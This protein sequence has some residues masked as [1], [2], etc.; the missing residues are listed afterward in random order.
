MAL[1]L[2]MLRTYVLFKTFDS[3]NT[4]IIY[5]ERG[6]KNCALEK[7]TPSKP[8]IM[9]LNERIS[10]LEDELQIVKETNSRQE[11]LGFEL[12]KNGSQ[13]P[14]MQIENLE[15][16][17]T[18]TF[19]KAKTMINESFQKLLE[20]EK[21]ST[22]ENKKILQETVDRSEMK[23]S[24][25]VKNL[26]ISV[27][28]LENEIKDQLKRTE[29]DVFSH[30]NDFD[31]KLENITTSIQTTN[32]RLQLYGV[33][34]NSTIFLLEQ[35]IKNLRMEQ[36][37]L[38]EDVASVNKKISMLKNNVSNNSAVLQHQ[39]S[40]LTSNMS[41]VTDE[42]KNNIS[43]TMEN[44]VSLIKVWLINATNDLNN[45]MQLELNKSE[46]N[47]DQTVQNISISMTTL[48]KEITGN[49]NN[50]R[51]DLFSYK[52]DLQGK[53]KN[54]T[55]SIHNTNL[56]LELGELNNN[57]TISLLE[58]NL[59]NLH[60][61]QLTLVDDVASANKE[62]SMLISNLTKTSN[63]LQHQFSDFTLKT[64]SLTEEIK[65]EQHDMF[66][67]VAN[68][69]SSTME[70][71]V[72]L[73]KASL[74]NATN[75]M[76]NLIQL[77]LN[78]S[79]SKIDLTVQN[80]SI[81]MT[82]LE[83]EITDKLNNVRQD[84]FSYKNDLQGKLKNITTSIHNTNV[85]LELGELNNNSTISLLEQNLQN[86]HKEQLTLV[87]DVASA[88]KE[89][90]MLISN[91][92]KTSNVLQHQFSDFTLKTSSLTEEI[93]K[94]QHD[95]FGFVAN[96]ISSTME[97]EVSL[98]KASLTNATNTMNN[99][100]QLE[101]NKS[102]SKKDQ[103]V[104]N[105]SISMT[106]LENEIT[107]MLN[108][109]RQ[110]LF[111][112][113]NDLQGKL[114]NITTSIH[115]TNVRL[116]LGE[117]NNNST[118][119][120][121][122]QNL[123]N[124][125]KEQLTL[126]DDVASANKEIS[127]L[128]SN[129]T[130]TSNVLQNQFSEFTS[131]MSSLKEEIKKEQHDTFGFVANNISSAVENEVSL[132]KAS[133]TNATN[134]VNN[135]IQLE[136][137]KSDSKI[138]L[139][140]QNISISLTMLENGITGKLKNIRQDVS[141]YKNDLQGTLENITTSIQTTIERLELDVV[142][143]NFTIS[144][145][146]HN[147]QNLLKEQLTLVDDVG[148]ANKE[149]NML[150]TNL[151]KTLN[152]L[153]QQSSELTS[154]MSSWTK[155]IKKEQHDMFGFVTNNISSAMDNE[156][157]IMTVL[158][159]NA[160]N[161][162]NNLIQLEL[163]KSESKIDLTV[164]NISNF[165]SGLELELKS[166][167]EN[168]RQ[169]VMTNKND[170]Q[171]KCEKMV[172]D[173]ALINLQLVMEL[174]EKCSISVE[175]VTKTLLKTNERLNSEERKHN[176]TLISF[177]D[178][179]NVFL[180]DK[181]TLA[182]NI[183][184]TKREMSML[185]NKAFE[186]SEANKIQILELT[187]NISTFAKE[188][189]KGQN[190][191]YSRMTND[192]SKEIANELSSILISLTTMTRRIDDQDR[193]IVQNMSAIEFITQKCETQMQSIAFNTS[194]KI[195][196]IE[197]ILLTRLEKQEFQNNETIKGMK[198][199]NDF[200]EEINSKLNETSYQ[201]I[202]VYGD[203]RQIRQRMDS[204]E[205]N[206]KQLEIYTNSSLVHIQSIEAN[207]SIFKESAF[208]TISSKVDNAVVNARQLT[209]RLNQVTGSISTLQSKATR[210]EQFHSSQNTRLSN[211]ESRLSSAS[212]SLTNIKNDLKKRYSGVI[213]LTN[214]GRTYGRVEVYHNGAW[215]TVCD[216]DWDTSDA[217]VACR[218][219]G[220]SGGTAR[221]EAYY[222]QGTGTIWLDDLGCTGYEPSLFACRHLTI[223]SHNCNHG[224][225]AGVSCSY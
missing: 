125:H 126:V 176:L 106:T 160:T 49:L 28:K 191:F 79:E 162:M 172:N 66:G 209:S 169:E 61:E 135:L 156:L 76:N 74:T 138:D 121:L 57:S 67:F 45:L 59:Q 193:L 94:E 132:I 120:L 52:N 3:G 178:K 73:I 24:E 98:I 82:T 212:S 206:Q 54:I 33:N 102:E 177:E 152:V 205:N 139:T 19:N 223:G 75:T 107:D 145:L 42:I 38:V 78:K 34:N 84:L 23:L 105:I 95:M 185:E 224:E 215:G 124:L 149:L 87:D 100:I 161:T 194:S 22:I 47:I 157:S 158:L 147:A 133:L 21:N 115:N 18:M 7:L 77:E 69:I 103:T 72:S 225:D 122:E 181:V 90:S 110:D 182:E 91:L 220:L 118:I 184:K 63:V 203:F 130:K 96:N 56:R 15:T 119:S 27:S 70:N 190:D 188:M 16:K 31:R 11:I 6:E 218:M 68:N 127:M 195:T 86:L 64:S 9:L 142:N 117:L 153:Q 114:K 201:F 93:K 150:K 36:L 39:F 214:G 204:M 170:Y 174:D 46:S 8:V 26:S 173:S 217:Q 14:T 116:E 143:N 167:I 164:Q 62:I 109:V 97:N 43:S 10:N 30:R 35:S 32:E 108:N 189:E 89:I 175:N 128:I 48:E 166:N 111:S 2:W 13:N 20:K 159:T 213:R 129:L 88:N 180:N 41:S 165:L 25:M 58:Q 140:V 123:Q 171:E 146:K 154:N 198:H 186:K 137:N 5:E 99:L 208:K 104:Q 81:S 92:T 65:K 155:E 151:T 202:N 1:L 37:T 144:L 196:D 197:N 148:S 71:E 113:K 222:G 83:N 80:I 200:S 50:V 141:S 85:R 29:Q 207:I 51:Q 219:M 216:D 192:M 168:V 163:N 101:L 179:L 131:N 187:S 136:L 60:K 17:L 55:T 211:I 53:L 199:L 12:L 4:Q 183:D 40:E 134:T 112:Y 44:E 210:F 221:N